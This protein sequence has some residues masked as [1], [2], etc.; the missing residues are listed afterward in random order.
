VADRERES[1]QGDDSGADAGASLNAQLPLAGIRVLDMS[2]VMAGPFCCMLL[3]DMGADVIKVEPPG[4]GDQTRRSMG[5]RMKGEDSPGFLALNRNK[6]S[7]ALNLKSEA[8]R[9]VLYRLVETADVV[10]ENNRPGVV[11]KLQADYETLSKINPRLVYA[12][13]SGFGQYGPWAQRPGFDLIAQAMTGVISATGIPGAEPVKSGVPVGDLGAGM[14]ATY[15]ILAAIIGR[16]KTGRGQYIDTSLFDAAMALSVWETTEFWATGNSPGPLGTANRMSAPYQAFAASDG[17]FVVGAA[18][19]RLWLRFIEV[20]NR[21]ELLNDPRYVEN[22][23]RVANR[24]VL[25]EDLAPTFLTRSAEEWVDRFLAAGVPAGPIYDYRQALD[26]DH[27][28]ARGSMIEVDH[29]IE[30]S[31]RAL[32]FPVKMSETKQQVRYPPPLL[33]EHT[34][35]LLAELGLEGEAL[36]RE[37][38]FS[39]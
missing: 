6:R 15:A 11:K 2:Q 34:E 30:G 5:F 9:K 10:V 8:G 31:F 37:G 3:G 21:P 18:N 26:S 38:A 13:I 35:T 28:A 12:S 24:G 19:Q 22:K 20:V 1:S 23:D 27:A 16:G 39:A 33:G 25:A 17:K 32:G 14:F 36:A 7:I 4:V 29:P